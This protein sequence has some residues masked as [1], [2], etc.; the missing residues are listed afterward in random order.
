M[1]NERIEEARRNWAVW[2]IGEK[3]G[4]DGSTRW[5]NRVAGRAA[6]D[7]LARDELNTL[8]P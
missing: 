1:I 2:E 4:Q 8:M 6:I 5:L 7:L 3:I